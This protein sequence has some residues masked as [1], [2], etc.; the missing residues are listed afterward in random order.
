MFSFKQLQQLII[1][2]EE[3][4][5]TLKNA[6]K[7]SSETLNLC[8]ILQQE[9]TRMQFY[10]TLYYKTRLRK[11]HQ[12]ARCQEGDISTLSTEE[13]KL[14]NEYKS[15]RKDYLENSGIFDPVSEQKPS[16]GSFVFVRVLSTIDDFKITP[17]DEE[18]LELNK[19]EIF[20]FPYNSV[21]NFINTSLLE[22]I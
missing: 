11:I 14:Y 21:H 3:T 2:Q 9:I 12:I 19:G 20:L 1:G 4:I 15:L 6:D 17:D 7:V 5:E 13:V 16:M 10:L 22:L 8:N 18:G